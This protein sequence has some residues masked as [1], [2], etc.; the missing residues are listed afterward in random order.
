MLPTAF[1]LIVIPSAARNLFPA[2]T[3][4]VEMLHFVQ[5]DRRVADLE[6]ARFLLA[7]EKS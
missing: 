4:G 1:F 6:L 3:L 5:H 2:S 7:Q